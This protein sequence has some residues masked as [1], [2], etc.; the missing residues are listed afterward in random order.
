MTDSDEEYIPSPSGH[1][2]IPRQI[3][4]SIASISASSGRQRPSD[5]SLS[6]EE[7]PVSS[8][9]I[10][11]STS[12]IIQPIQIQPIPEIDPSILLNSVAPPKPTG[13]SHQLCEK[14][15]WSQSAQIDQLVD[16]VNTLTTQ[17]SVLSRGAESY[18]DKTQK[19]MAKQQGRRN[20]YSLSL[21]DAKQKIALANLKKENS[22][23]AKSIKTLEAK[24][25]SKKEEC[26]TNLHL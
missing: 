24:L 4:G 7:S 16:T 15:F 14:A 18:T 13:K 9:K 25:S 3:D 10:T 19:L 5:S 12:V 21:N 26:D 6:F 23:F 20:Q 1:A 11:V 8:P 17:L 2:K 22:E